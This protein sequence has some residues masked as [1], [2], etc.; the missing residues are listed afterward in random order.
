MNPEGSSKTTLGARGA[1]RP[2]HFPFVAECFS[3]LVC[4]AA[5]AGPLPALL[6]HFHHGFCF[7]SLTHFLILMRAGPGLFQITSS[8]NSELASVDY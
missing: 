4:F 8:V 1:A 2:F 3:I 7:V 6:E 5:A